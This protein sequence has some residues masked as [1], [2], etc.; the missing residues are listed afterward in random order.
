MVC[1]KDKF[2]LYSYL[3]DF[4]QYWIDLENQILTS[5]YY[6]QYYFAE[7][8]GCEWLITAPEGNILSLEFS[9]FEVRLIQKSSIKNLKKIFNIIARRGYFNFCFTIWWYMW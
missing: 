9:H 8:G 5:P 7:G 1:Y 4:C 6:P 3:G 2:W